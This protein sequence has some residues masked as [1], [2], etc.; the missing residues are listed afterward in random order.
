MAC[1]KVC[2]QGRDDAWNQRS[3]YRQAPSL[4]LFHTTGKQCMDGSLPKTY[5]K[6][7]WD[8]WDEAKTM[9]CICTTLS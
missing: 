9:P 1:Q 7:P 2:K 5:Q 4:H 3:T 6:L 8:H